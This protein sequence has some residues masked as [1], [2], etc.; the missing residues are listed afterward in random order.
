MAEARI[1]RYLEQSGRHR[2]GAFRE[3]RAG[4]SQ[5][6]EELL[7]GSLVGAVKAVALSRGVDLN[8]EE[9]VRDYLSTLAAQS[10]DRRLVDAFGHLSRFAAMQDR[11]YDLSASHD[12]LHHL[13]ERI[14]HA[15]QRL[16]ELV[17]DDEEDA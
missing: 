4:E 13:A 3:M 5:R 10:R 11:V 7:W 1:H 6:A 9:E 8:G 14:G 16:W 15:V 17:H 2:E 12:Q